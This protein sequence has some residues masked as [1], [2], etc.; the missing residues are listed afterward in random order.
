[1]YVGY[2]TNIRKRLSEHTHHLRKGAH[3]NDYLQKSWN[4]YGESNFKLEILEE[5]DIEFMAS[6][7]NYWCNLLST[8]NEIYGYNIEPTSPYNKLTLAQSTKD[9]ISRANK[10]KP[11]SEEW[12]RKI[13][14]A[15]KGKIL[16]EYEKQR[17]RDM[18]INRGPMSQEQ[19][20]KISK[21][22]K[23]RKF[24][25]ETIKKLT[26]SAKKRAL[27]ICKCEICGE[28]VKITRY[29]T[30]H[31][32]NC[33]RS[34]KMSEETKKKISKKAL[35][36]KNLKVAI[37]ICQFT[38]DGVFVAEYESITEASKITK[39]T[40]TTIGKQL[41]NGKTRKSIYEWYKK[42]LIR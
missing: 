36:R 7:E 37:P 10:G 42:D 25:E 1:M 40:G 28:E 38:L 24:S 21:G 17:L 13:S 3:P 20:D 5:C 15:H 33:G 4:K 29:Y 35:G 32:K 18:N 9:K 11:K 27:E 26:L 19:K 2:A 31:G 41:K 30:F 23:G 16:S 39:I 8:H 14:E 6:F 34:T 12:K 22:L